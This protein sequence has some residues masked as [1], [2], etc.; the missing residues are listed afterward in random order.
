MMIAIA[1][2]MIV[3]RQGCEWEMD[4]RACIRACVGT[5]ACV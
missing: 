3:F 1:R 4:K 2:N 5:R